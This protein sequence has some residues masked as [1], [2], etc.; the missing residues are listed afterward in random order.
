[1]RKQ[2]GMA[3]ESIAKKRFGGR[4]L[5]GFL[6]N[7]RAML[8]LVLLFSG[9]SAFAP[10]FFSIHNVTTILKGASLN[11]IVAIGFTVI[12][13]LGQLD[14][15]IGAVVMLCGMLTIGL[16]PAFGWFGSISLAVLAGASAGLINGLL[17]VKAKINSFIVTLGTM[18]VLTGLMHLYSKGGSKAIDDF[19]F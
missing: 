5:P 18:T 6:D 19:R 8:M 13:I 7:N 2:A 12:F 10:N 15:S 1:M 3:E 14:L 17:V 9:L 11:A 16:Q 4:S